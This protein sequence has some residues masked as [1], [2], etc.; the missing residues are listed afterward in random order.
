MSYGKQ[1][2]RAI[3]ARLMGADRFERL[4]P[5]F[6]YSMQLPLAPHESRRHQSD[7]LPAAQRLAGEPEVTLGLAPEAAAEEAARCLRCDVK[8]APCPVR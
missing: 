6:H 7:E 2:A 1:A 5:D 4:W 8:E 3:D